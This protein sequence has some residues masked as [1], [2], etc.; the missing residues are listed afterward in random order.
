MIKS[1]MYSC[2]HSDWRKLLGGKELLYILPSPLIVG[3]FIQHALASSMLQ[4]NEGRAFHRE[5]LCELDVSR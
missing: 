2:I 5:Y 4:R 3:K 1:W